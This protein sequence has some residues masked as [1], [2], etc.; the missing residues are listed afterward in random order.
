VI[1]TADPT[2]SFKEVTASRGKVVRA[3]PI[4][5]LFEQ[6]RVSIANGLSD[7]EDQLCAM[8]SEGYVGGGLPDR[9]DA[10][11]WALTELMITSAGPATVMPLWDFL[12]PRNQGKPWQ[13]RR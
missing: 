12:H 5:A 9:A 6:S 1:R 10:M 13:I 11:V 3:E 7:L 8:T 4:A 2:V